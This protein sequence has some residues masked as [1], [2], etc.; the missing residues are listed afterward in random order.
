MDL[1]EE[2]EKGTPPVV[3][4]LF[5]GSREQVRMYCSPVSLH[6]LMLRRSLFVSTHSW[7][8]SSSSKVRRRRRAKTF[9]T[10]W[11]KETRTTSRAASSSTNTWG[12]T[13]RQCSC[14][15]RIS[16]SGVQTPPD[17]GVAH[18]SKYQLASLTLRLNF[19]SAFSWQNVTALSHE[20]LNGAFV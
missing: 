4:D 2:E 18:H 5:H 19:S 6:L 11:S 17:F 1:E 10:G 9:A 3:D 14:S 12:Q 7:I 8:K 20:L 16:R 13:M 15:S